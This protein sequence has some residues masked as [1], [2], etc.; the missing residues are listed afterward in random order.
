MTVVAETLKELGADDKPILLVFNKVD[1]AESP[2]QIQAL[3]AEY[4]DAAF[5]SALRGIGLGPLRTKLLDLV[6]ADFVETTVCVPVTDARAIAHIRRVAD[7]LDEDYTELSDETHDHQPVARLRIRLA[8][9]HYDD[10]KPML[11][12]GRH[13][14]LP[15]IP[16]ESE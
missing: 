15:P 16:T 13:V 14:E 10:L 12:A 2:E 5:V 11:R 1:A 8:S 7:I 4:P 9:K 6:E 3:Q